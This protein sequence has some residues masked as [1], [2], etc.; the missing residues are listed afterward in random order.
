[1]VLDTVPV[2]F[3]AVM[4]RIR[5]IV[6]HNIKNLLDHYPILCNAVFLSVISSLF[7]N[8]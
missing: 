5:Y 7:Q 1:M 4:C 3:L 2:I 6:R 8:F